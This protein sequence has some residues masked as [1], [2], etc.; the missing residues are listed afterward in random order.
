MDHPTWTSD[1]AKNSDDIIHYE[2]T[3]HLVII[4]IHIQ[5]YDKLAIKRVYV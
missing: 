1:S 2:Y 4:A 3:W 5:Y